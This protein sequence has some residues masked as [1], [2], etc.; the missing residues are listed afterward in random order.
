MQT[1]V[2]RP[3]VIAAFAI[4]VIEKLM[5]GG[6]TAL[7]VAREQQSPLRARHYDH[8]HRGGK[9]HSSGA[10][11]PGYNDQTGTV[12]C[13]RTGRKGRTLYDQYCTALHGL[14]TSLVKVESAYD[15]IMGKAKKS[16]AERRSRVPGSGRC[17]ACNDWM[18]G[19][20][21]RNSRIKDGFCPAH[22]KGWHRAKRAGQTRS[23]YIGRVRRNRG[24][25]LQEDDA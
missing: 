7:T 21:D 11:D 10:D 9:S 17:V 2:P 8:D 24:V 1:Q 3:K 13:A 16:E 6:D 23:D 25:D 12:A 19:G 14:D 5:N 15:R 4:R 22:F 20:E 18:P